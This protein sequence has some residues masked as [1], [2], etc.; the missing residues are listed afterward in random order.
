MH[1]WDQII[2]DPNK[3]VQ[4][5]DRNSIEN[6]V[7]LLG[8]YLLL[9]VEIVSVVLLI[10]LLVLALGIIL[11]G[12]FVGTGKLIGFLRQFDFGIT[13]GFRKI[14]K[15]CSAGTESLV[16]DNDIEQGAENR[17]SPAPRVLNHDIDRG[18]KAPEAAPPYEE[19]K[20]NGVLCSWTL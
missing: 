14:Q 3:V 7:N 11:F 15:Y 16:L 12:A 5:P 18:T 2:D 10:G 9:L 8:L 20:P 1:I 13:V 17:S 6:I 19:T 4:T